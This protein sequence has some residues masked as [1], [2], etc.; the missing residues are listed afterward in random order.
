MTWGDGG[1][2]DKECE[3]VLRENQAELVVLMVIGSVK[4][5][6]FSVSARDL[7]LLERLP[8]FLEATAAKIRRDLAAKGNS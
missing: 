3:Q 6:G 5:S 7:R 8:A 1:K 4:G 2:Y